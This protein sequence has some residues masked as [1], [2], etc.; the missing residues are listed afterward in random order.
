MCEAG[1]KQITPVTHDGNCHMSGM[2]GIT[3]SRH[4]IL[5]SVE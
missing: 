3:E 4:L 5:G 2:Q 1:D